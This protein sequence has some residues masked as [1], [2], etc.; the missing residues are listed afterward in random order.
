[1]RFK[2]LTAMLLSASMVVGLLAG[3]TSGGSN[4]TPAPKET[5]PAT[6][7]AETTPADTTPV[8]G[9]SSLKGKRVRVVIGST[10]TGGDSYMMAD[11]VTRFL[12]EEMGFNGKVDPVGNAAALDAITK[13]KG[14]GTTIMM[15]HD[16]TFLSVLFGAVGEEYS[17]DNLTVGPRIGQNPGGCFAAN[18]AAPYDSL[19]GA[20]KWL[21]ENPDK[22]IRV[23]IESGSASHLCFVVWYL[24][25]KDTYGEDVSNRIK[26]VVGGTTDEKK[27]RLWDGNADIIYGDYS[28]FNEFTKE[29]VDAQ[30]AMKM[31]DSSGN[32]QGVD[33]LDTMA[34][35]GITFNGEPF[36]FNK[37]FSMYFPKDMDPAVL[38][39]IAA[40][41]Q[42][43]CANPDFQAEMAALKY[44]AVSPEETELAASQQFVL[45]K[46][47]TSVAIVDAAP[48]LDSMT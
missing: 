9:E 3:C 45:D 26:A 11:I 22:T 27:Q 17:L 18:A 10:S 2:K 42:K 37:D 31:M 44:N 34:N 46:R 14:D 25:A 24:W 48:S 40:A 15:F 33:N 41:M 4:P 29:G 6:T 20:A 21:S 35:D 38:N 16:M 36:D 1:M 32:I 43:V 28:A 19:A 13:A 30:L 23:N 12:G 5:T 8:S 47:D 39:E 7:P